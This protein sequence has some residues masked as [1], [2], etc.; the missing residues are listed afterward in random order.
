M[1][2]DFKEIALTFGT[3][4]YSEKGMADATVEAYTRDVRFFF[5]F[6]DTHNKEISS[7]SVVDYFQE[8]KNKNYAPA[9]MARITFSIKVLLK[10][11][12]REKKLDS[13]ILLFLER[14]IT[15]DLICDILTIE[16]M[17][18][19]LN[20]PD[21]KTFE[22]SR[23]RA[24]LEV[25]YSSGLRVSELCLLNISD[26]DDAFVKVLGKGQKERV[27]PIGIK[28]L[29]AIDDYSHYRD[30][31]KGNALFVNSRGNRIDR[32]TVWRRV[33]MYAKQACIEKNIFPHTFRHSFAT[34]LLDGGADLRVIQDMLGHSSIA[35]T[36]RYTHVSRDQIRDSFFKNHP[37]N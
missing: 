27:V 18:R 10:F 13:Q 2:I 25:L 8:L 19:L 20:A 32:I 37:R 30:A 36:E 3:Y 9:S 11:L 22:G 14:P 29:Q 12:I 16:E 21:T 7:E 1:K 34:H 23:D 35:S 31:F 24:I 26:V 15:W 5:T 17:E 28:A 6:L 33:K 4:L